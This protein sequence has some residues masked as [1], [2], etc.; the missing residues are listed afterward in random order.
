MNRL[1]NRS[2]SGSKFA[3]LIEVKR[4]VKKDNTFMHLPSRAIVLREA[5]NFQPAL[6]A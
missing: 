1:Y 5:L 3:T 6:L 4:E 2:K